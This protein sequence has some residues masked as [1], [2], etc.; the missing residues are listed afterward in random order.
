MGFECVLCGA[1]AEERR[2]VARPWTTR[3]LGAT[4]D[5]D[6]VDMVERACVSGAEPVRA[7]SG[8]VGVALPDKVGPNKNRFA[9]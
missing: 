6:R 4:F 7:R 5:A 9:A 8:G 2:A 3:N 1:A